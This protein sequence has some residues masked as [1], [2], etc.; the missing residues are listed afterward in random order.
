MS[1]AYHKLPTATRKQSTQASDQTEETII[2]KIFSAYISSPSIY[3]IYKIIYIYN[4]PRRKWPPSTPEI[5]SGEHGGGR[6]SVEF[7][8]A[9]GWLCGRCPP[10]GRAWARSPPRLLPSIWNQKRKKKKHSIFLL[11]GVT[12][13]KRILKKCHAWSVKRR[14]HSPADPC[15]H[16]LWR[17]YHHRDLLQLRWFLLADFV[18]LFKSFDMTAQC[19]ERINIIRAFL[20]AN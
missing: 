11:S 5:A 6:R 3:Y 16:V 15:G 4:A 17:H 1:L 8:A 18:L 7:T 20:E 10:V 9:S 2:T 13:G 19:G 12:L 14:A